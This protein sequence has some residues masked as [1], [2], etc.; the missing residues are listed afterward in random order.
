[1]S[2]AWTEREVIHLLNRT[3]FSVNREIIDVCLSYGMEETVNQLIAGRPLLPA[4]SA[5]LVPIEQLKMGSGTLKPGLLDDQSLY[6]LYRMMNSSA[7]LIEKMALFWHGHFATSFYKIQNVSLMLKQID[8]FRNHALGSFRDLLLS[9]SKDP[10]MMLWLDAGYNK[11]GN[12]NENYSRELMELFT[13]GIGNYSEQDVREA[14]RAFTGWSYNTETYKVVFN[15]KQFDSGTKTFL[16]ETGNFGMVEI[17]DILIKQ[18]ALYTF[19][20]RKLLQAF[21]VEKPS[22][23]WISQFAS[24]LSQAKT[25][26]EAMKMLL[27]SDEFYQEST[28]MSLVK[29][30][31]EFMTSI[32]K[33]LSLPLDIHFIYAIKEMGQELYA[34]PN[35]AGWPGHASWLTTNYY[36]AR[37]QFAEYASSR[38]TKWFAPWDK[39]IGAEAIIKEWCRLLGIGKLSE[40]S[41]N[42][43]LTYAATA[44]DPTNLKVDAKRKLLQLLLM[45]PEAQLK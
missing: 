42:G 37:F 5:P 39:P 36:L 32:I 3:A 34:P 4:K 23:T 8:M 25:I 21:A 26:G 15:D 31:P 45:C 16:G 35:V 18:K 43:L 30:P 19:L 2:T 17:I 40:A 41:L 28:V 1:M 29:S 9:V 6:W 11:K 38:V 14:A 10:A 20:A 44:P 33:T 12:P 13:L 22:E 7:P 27:M 24:Q